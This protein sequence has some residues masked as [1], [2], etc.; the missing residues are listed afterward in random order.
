MSESI[1]DRNQSYPGSEQQLPT[2]VLTP[3]AADYI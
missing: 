2:V 3:I 1:L